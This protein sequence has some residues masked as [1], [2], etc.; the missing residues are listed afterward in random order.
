MKSISKTK[1][2]DEV[3]TSTTLK[4][5]WFYAHVINIQAIEIGITVDN[6]GKSIVVVDT[7]EAGNFSSIRLERLEL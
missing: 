5:C 3:L 6:D 1:D 2:N 7:D 4:G